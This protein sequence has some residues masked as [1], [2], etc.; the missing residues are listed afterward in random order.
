MLGK[1][2]LDLRYNIL[3]VITIIKFLLFSTTK[4]KIKRIIERLIDYSSLA[5]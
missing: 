3:Y 1:K 2:N 5:S 4:Y